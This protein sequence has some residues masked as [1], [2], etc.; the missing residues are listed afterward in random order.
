MNLTANGTTVAIRNDSK[1]R[2]LRRKLENEDLVTT[3]I[4]VTRETE[5]VAQNVSQF[6]SKRTVLISGMTIDL[7][8][9]TGNKPATIHFITTTGLLRRETTI[10]ATESNLVATLKTRIRRVCTVSARTMP[11]NF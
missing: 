10:R 6:D 4:A 5:L 7:Q 2:F 11:T 8:T 9:W 3:T 1:D